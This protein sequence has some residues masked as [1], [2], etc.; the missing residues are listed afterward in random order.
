MIESLETAR[1]ITARVEDVTT[2]NCPVVSRK[3]YIRYAPK[4]YIA[5]GK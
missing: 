1:S 4:L 2:Q 3:K 5:Y